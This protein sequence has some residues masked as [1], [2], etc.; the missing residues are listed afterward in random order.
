M[1][2]LTSKYV[3]VF[4]RSRKEK[5][6]NRGRNIT[7]SWHLNRGSDF[8]VKESSKINRPSVRGITTSQSQIFTGKEP[9]DPAQ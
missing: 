3:E 8:F 5:Q 2:R 6:K 1:P 7:S 9:P 4:K